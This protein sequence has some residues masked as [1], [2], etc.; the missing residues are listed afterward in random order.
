[1]KEL[2]R[3]TYVEDEP[4]IRE[5]VQLALEELGGYTLHVCES[6]AEALDSAPI[7]HPD[8][9]L[10]DVMMPGMNGIQTY[11]ALREV[12]EIAITPIIFVT[13]KAQS[14]E[15]EQYKL[16]GAAGVISK[17]F[18]P[19]TLPADIQAIWIQVLNEPQI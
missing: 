7:F 19:I 2:Q 9:V 18:N 12:P 15:I 1:M 11:R 17:P 5:I 14:H 13:A 4:H 3:I 16:L 8:L 6:G 10:L